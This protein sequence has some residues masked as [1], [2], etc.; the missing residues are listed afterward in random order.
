MSRISAAAR[1]TI[2]S[3]VSRSGIPLSENCKWPDQRGVVR[4]LVLANVV[5]R[6]DR[7]TVRPFAQHVTKPTEH[8]R[9]TFGGDFDRTIRTIPNPARQAEVAR[10]L[11]DIP[12]E[13]H[14]L[15]TPAHQDVELHQPPP[16]PP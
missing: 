3:K 8:M 13:A 1:W 2:A 7:R 15:H 5:D 10:Y 14:S 12:S 16:V 6:C 4:I 11:A 9:L